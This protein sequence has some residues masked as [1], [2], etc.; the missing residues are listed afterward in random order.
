MSERYLDKKGLAMHY[1]CSV[2]SIENALAE[3]LPHVVG[4]GRV[5]FRVSEVEPWLWANGYLHAPASSHTVDANAIAPA[6][7]DTAR[8]H[9]QGGTPDGT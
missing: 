1:S 6:T 4:F 5:K 3:G 8:A 9:D 7:A 2:R